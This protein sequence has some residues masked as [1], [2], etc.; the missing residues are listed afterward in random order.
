[1]SLLHRT[2]SSPNLKGK[3]R[4]EN[5]VDPSW[6]RHSNRPSILDR[7]YRY[8]WE[9]QQ[10]K[11]GYETEDDEFYVIGDRVYVDGFRPASVAYFGEVEFGK[12]DWVGV[13]LDEP[14]G[15]H[16]GRLHG[17]QYFQCAPLHGLFVRPLRV[18]RMPDSAIGSSA[19][20]SRLSTP[21][22]NY[23]RST[24]RSPAGSSVIGSYFYDED[25]RSDR[26]TVASLTKKLRSINERPSRVHQ[27]GTSSSPLSRASSSEYRSPT[28]T[29]YTGILKRGG[30]RS[31]STEPL[32][33]SRYN[34]SSRTSASPSVFN[35]RPRRA[36]LNEFESSSFDDDRRLTSSSV[37]LTNEP[38][39]IGDPVV[40]RSDR[41]EMTGVLRFMGETN[42]ATGEWAGIELDE[43]DG[44]NDGSVLGERY[45]YCA[46]NHGLFVPAVRVRKCNKATTRR[47]SDFNSMKSTIKSPPPSNSWIQ[48]HRSRSTTPSYSDKLSPY[49]SSDSFS[50]SST[51]YKTGS[52]L[53]TLPTPSKYVH[54]SAL[55]GRSKLFSDTPL[56]TIPS[57]SL[58]NTKL[59]YIDDGVYDNYT[60]RRERPKFDEADIEAQLK[61]SLRRPPLRTLTS[62]KP[63]S[64][65]I[66]TSKP[67]SVKYTF[68]SSKYDGNPIVRRTVEY[69]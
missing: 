2:Y 20:S 32:A 43:P 48:E 56:P 63:I 60:P 10:E 15:N 33:S 44:K 41:G 29:R 23:G 68:S 67:R 21:L 27:L 26:P 28:P 18:S 50:R 66:Q 51:P 34:L 5:F 53:T 14:S 47:L 62:I 36:K 31:Q 16:D 46:K 13:V 1:M 61:K 69:N 22:P 37:D 59:S 12:G 57:K 35:F 4:L 25:Y 8:E 11:Y 39:R 38:A 58:V 9:S 6:L 3:F 49:P 54:S 64:S 30:Q 45:F 19:A 17:R 40:F 52:S 42:F 7:T 55:G 65:N 24:S